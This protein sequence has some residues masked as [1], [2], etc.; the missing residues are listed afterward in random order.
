MNKFYLT[1][2]LLIPLFLY[3]AD[4]AISNPRLDNAFYFGQFR[5]GYYGSYDYSDFDAEDHLHEARV[6]FRLGAGYHFTPHL[7]F[8]TRLAGRYSTEQD[9][10]R[11]WLDQNLPTRSGLRYGD[12]T[13]DIFEFIWSPTETLSLRVGRFQS[14][15][16]LRSTVA[17]GLHRYDNPNVLVSWTDGIKIT[18]RAF[19]SWNIE[20]TGE[21]NSTDG[22]GSVAREPLEFSESAS[23][24][25][26][27]LVLADAGTEGAWEQREIGFH[28][29]PSSLPDNGGFDHYTLIATRL[30]YE[31]EQLNWAGADYF[32]GLE[33]GFAP[34]APAVPEL[35]SRENAFAFQVV[36]YTKGLL[37]DTN[38][39]LLYGFADPGWLVS[40]S[41]RPNSHSYEVR[42]QR[43]FTSSLSAEVRY[44]LRTD[45]FV[46]E[47][48]GRRDGD[49]YARITYRF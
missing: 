22:P 13:I 18:W 45:P 27:T 17:K 30:I 48:E 42:Y 1:T 25:S 15:Y 19:D 46:G 47:E 6:R 31:F 49:V 8:Q 37:K 2:I 5:T 44:R 20:Y 3:N 38:L 32:L 9:K 21:Y 41:F 24:V 35:H 39:G 43:F 28:I 36:G 4:Q 23:R 34:A 40:P 11:F 26:H 12:T 14:G 7:T 10:F 16:S 33:G 29:V